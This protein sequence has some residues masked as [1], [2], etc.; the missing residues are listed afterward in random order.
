[1]DILTS[2]QLIRRDGTNCTIEQL[3]DA[4]FIALYFAS[5]RSGACR[6][7]R[8]L[9]SSVVHELRI[10]G[11]CLNV[12]VV[13]LDRSNAEMMDLLTDCRDYWP[14]V[15]FESDA[16]MALLHRFDVV[17]TPTVVILNRNG[18]VVSVFGRDYIEIDG[19]DVWDRWTKG[20]NPDA[21]PK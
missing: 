15:P 5:Q 18:N 10:S 4:Q 13:S 7:F 19:A 6:A 12:I 11:R 1:M 14:A 2:L 8:G 17:Q 16:R 21:E 20:T 9:L 3:D